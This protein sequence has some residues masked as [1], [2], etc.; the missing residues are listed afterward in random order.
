VNIYSLAKY[1]QIKPLMDLAFKWI[2]CGWDSD[3]CLEIYKHFKKIGDE[4]MAQ[5]FFRVYQ[6]YIREIHYQ[7]L[8]FS[9]ISAH[10]GYLQRNF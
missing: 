5:L 2:D 4:E 8:F 9:L 7:I 10:S 6:A 3:T 1:F